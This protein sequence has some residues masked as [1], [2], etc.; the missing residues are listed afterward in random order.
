MV[1]FLPLALAAANKMVSG[2]QQDQQALGQA[3]TLPS[4]PYQFQQPRQ[5]SLTGLL[6]MG[7]GLNWQSLIGGNE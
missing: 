4:T 6:N 2:R 3:L 1:Q 5:G 7:Q